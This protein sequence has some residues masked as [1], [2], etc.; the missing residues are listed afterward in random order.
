M[1]SAR[2]GNWAGFWMGAL[3]E[4]PFFATTVGIGREIALTAQPQRDSIVAAVGDHLGEFEVDRVARVEGGDHAGLGAGV[5]ARALLLRIAQTILH[6]PR[7]RLVQDEMSV[8]K[9]RRHHG[10]GANEGSK[11]T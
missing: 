2:R 10:G 5:P 8:G 7:R 3:M 6:L 9:R 4:T 11:E 1:P